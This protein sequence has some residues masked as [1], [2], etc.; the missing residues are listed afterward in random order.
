LTHALRFNNP[1]AKT[2]VKE[3]PENFTTFKPFNIKE[4]EYEVW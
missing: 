1:N 4:T 2:K 3:P